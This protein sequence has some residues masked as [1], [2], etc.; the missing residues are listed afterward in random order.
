[1]TKLLRNAADVTSVSYSF[2]TVI[3]I[4]VFIKGRICANTLIV[5]KTK[6]ETTVVKM[7]NI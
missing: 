6:Y 7:Q 5:T 2:D 4:N 3:E 1:M